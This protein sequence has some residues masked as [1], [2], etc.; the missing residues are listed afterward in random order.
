MAGRGQEAG[1][2]RRTFARM[3]GTRF[4]AITMVALL[5]T[6]A[7]PAG[8]A[9][10]PADEH[11]N[12]IVAAGG[13]NLSNGIFLPGTAACDNSGCTGVPMQIAKGT[14][15][16]FVNIDPAPVTNSHRIISLDKRRK[17][18]R[19]LFASDTVDG[20]GQTLMITS[21]LKPKVYPYFC[22]FHFGMYGQ[23]EVVK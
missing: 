10:A 7:T 22:S 23:I 3:K 15:V 9:S 11:P 5:A 21:H 6:L 8:A 16:T 14:D 12:V 20:P 4:S 18:G 1:L 19:P 17:T 13:T 2:R